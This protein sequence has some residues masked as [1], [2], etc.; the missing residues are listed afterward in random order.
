[1]DLN[2]Q[3]ADYKSAALPIELYQ[4]VSLKNDKN[5]TVER[6]RRGECR[7]FIIALNS[8]EELRLVPRG[9]IEPPTQ[10]FSILCSTD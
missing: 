7:F 1:M 8:A 10:G 6:K 4:H 3:P 5:V 9:G 2:Q